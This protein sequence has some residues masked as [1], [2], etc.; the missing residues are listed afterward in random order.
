M[1]FFEE[2]DD[3]NGDD[4]DACLSDCRVAR[5]GDGSTHQGVEE[6][7]DANVV[8]ETC[9]YGEAECV[10]CD[11]ECREVAGETAFC[12]DGQTQ[13]PEECD[14]GEN[15]LGECEYGALECEVCG[16]ACTRVAG[17]PLRCGDGRIDG[18][19]VCDGEPDCSDD[20]L[21]LR[22]QRGDARYGEE[23]DCGN[24]CA[25][26]LCVNNPH[27]GRGQ[28]TQECVN[29]GLCPGIDRCVQVPY[30]APQGQC[31]DPGLD[32]EVGDLVDICVPNETG[33]ACFQPEDCPIDGVCLAPPNPLVGQIP[34]PSQCAA[35][36]ERDNQ[37]PTGYRCEEVLDQNG[38]PLRICNANVEITRC[39][40]GNQNLCGGICRTR[41][42]EDE[43]S[44]V[45]CVIPTNARDGFCSCLCAT[46]DDCPRG[47][48][49]SPQY[50]SGNPF[51]PFACIPMAGYICPGG[52]QNLC[53][54]ESCLFDPDIGLNQ[55]TSACRNEGDC[56]QGFRCIAIP[57]SP[58]NYCAP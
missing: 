26:G 31:P 19:E 45:A 5:C 49:C 3:A 24:D 52:N 18:P 29:G 21:S 30:P 51:R 50:A 9:D 37:C 35:R 36:C 41:P 33:I 2:C 25:S 40:G 56:P 34:V 53:L 7:D 39:A 4:T 23:C 12:G 13:A 55:C 16:P 38:Q 44:V 47:F 27:L 20:C 8:T 57:G 42:G 32:F 58:F 43:A 15:G 1:D 46:A 22:P 28:C 54:G 6:C 17:Q 14:E 11:S 10:V 48:G